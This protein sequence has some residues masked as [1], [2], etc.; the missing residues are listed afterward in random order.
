M[1][2]N[3]ETPIQNPA[4]FA[5]R[6]RIADCEAGFCE[7]RRLKFAS[8]RRQ[9]RSVLITPS[10]SPRQRC[11]RWSPSVLM[12]LDSDGH[13]LNDLRVAPLQFAGRGTGTGDPDHD[14]F[15]DLQGAIAVIDPNET[16]RFPRITESQVIG[17]DILL[18]FTAA[19]GKIY[20]GTARRSFRRSVEC[21]DERFARH[22][23]PVTFL[24]RRRGDQCNESVL[25]H[26]RQ[27]IVGSVAV[28]HTR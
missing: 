5:T 10:D 25:P 11:F 14:R 21:D 18:T 2:M 15:T 16:T 23:T 6:C 26:S 7:K 24:H 17:S 3:L 8:L 20:A 4:K 12:Q 9:R 28:V 13:G 19:T 1:R 22:P 27:S